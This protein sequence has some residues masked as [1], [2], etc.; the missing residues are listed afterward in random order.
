MPTV[1][2]MSIEDASALGAFWGGGLSAWCGG[3]PWKLIDP[4]PQPNPPTE[5]AV[6]RMETFLA[7]NPA[8]TTQQILDELRMVSTMSALPVEDR[9]YLF[10]RATFGPDA[11]KGNAVGKHKAVLKG[12]ILSVDEAAYQRRCVGFGAWVC[13]CDCVCKLGGG[14]GEGFGWLVAGCLLAS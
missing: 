8:A 2:N 13:F 1:G 7:S 14:G 4:L 5:S 3:C 6:Q 10:V 9:M 12:L 11:A